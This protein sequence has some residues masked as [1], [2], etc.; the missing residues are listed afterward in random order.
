MEQLGQKW[1][2]LVKEIRKIQQNHS[3][4]T[5]F[6]PIFTPNLKKLGCFLA[7]FKKIRV[8]LGP[9]LKNWGVFCPNFKKFDLFLPQFKKIRVFFGPIFH[10]LHS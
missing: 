9:I 6:S 3:N 8:F 5:K 2:S 1:N 10:R 4:I 7:Q